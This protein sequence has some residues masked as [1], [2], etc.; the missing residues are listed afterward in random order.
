MAAMGKKL[1]KL[2]SS[3]CCK[4]NGSNAAC[5]F[6]SCTRDGRP[7]SDCFPGMNGHC[8]NP[9]TNA[10]V[11][12]VPPVHHIAAN[13]LAST[14]LPSSTSFVGSKPTTAATPTTTC[15]GKYWQVIN[16]HPILVPCSQK[17]PLWLKR[18]SGT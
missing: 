10:F 4:C 16:L 17:F 15:H 6:C 12:S 7:C 1:N 8:F 11:S 18:S 13:A 14:A 2:Q 3:H 5:R 9:K